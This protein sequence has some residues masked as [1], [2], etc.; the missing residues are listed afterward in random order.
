MAP[1]PSVEPAAIPP[2]AATAELH[3]PA[4]GELI[5]A[6]QV[7]LLYKQ[8]PVS[9]ASTMVGA[10]LLSGVMWE[11]LAHERIVGWFVCMALNQAWRLWLYHRFSGRGFEMRDLDKWANLWAVGSLISGCIW[12]AASFVMFVPDAPIY[13]AFLMVLLFGVTSAAVLLMGAHAPSFYAFVL[14][15]LL[16]VVVRN[17]LEGSGAHLTLAFIAG[18]TTL[19]LLSF[20]RTYNRVLI[21]S[22]RNR[23]HNE[24]LARELAHR[25]AELEKARAMAEQARNTAEIANR[26][27]TKFFAA[28][29]HDLR[30][31]LHALGLFAAALSEKVRDPEVLQVVNSVNASVE[32]LEGLFNELLDISK[33]DAGVIKPNPAHF[34]LG[35]LLGRL[36]MDFE[37][38][39]FERGLALRMRYPDL[40]VHSDPI[41]VERI[42]R[43]LIGNAL[44][45]TTAGG[46][47]IA[48]RRRGSNVSV[49]IWD[50]GRGIPPEE[51]ERIFEEFYQLGNPE[52]NSER[53]LGL[54]LSI[55]RRL[56]DLL[57]ASVSLRS[58]PGRG[59]MFALSLPLGTEPAP[60]AATAQPRS[61]AP[62]SL[63][64]SLIVVVEDEAAVREAMKVLLEGWGTE[65]LAAS[66]CADA[67]EQIA[68]HRRCPDVVIADYRLREG[69]NGVEAIRSLREHCGSRIPAIIISGSTMPL[70]IEE[71][72]ALGA[73]VLLKPVMPAKLRTLI[74]F[75]LKEAA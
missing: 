58:L 7:R 37:P 70:N 55:V 29:S 5:R 35:P 32:A 11:V 57:G 50:T 20:G 25:N 48:G 23:F 60:A 19:A 75:K 6:E 10:L 18:V 1:A 27:K 36:R 53:G 63:A 2:P 8:L 74:N 73:H 66:S 4:L 28:A 62:G 67:L 45:Y 22:L 38:E 34:A 72:K 52:R 14:P 42:L 30:Q 71:A 56:A 68:A 12:G 41:L 61:H 47:L 54:G 43:N 17:A 13:H 46:V 31:P 49:Q 69:R 16:P 40:Y 15:A 21:E 39:A 24:A 59:S 51:R 44:R 64:G 9:T 33:I 65:V 3:G 26:S